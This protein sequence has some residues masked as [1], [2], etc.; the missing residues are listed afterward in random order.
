MQF[1]FP[2]H[3]FNRGLFFSELLIQKLVFILLFLFT[4]KYLLNLFTRVNINI[5][6][7]STINRILLGKR[8]KRIC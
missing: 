3:D 7:K 5:A 8:Y 1:I 2:T 4:I 6:W